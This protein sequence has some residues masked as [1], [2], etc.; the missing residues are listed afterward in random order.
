MSMSDPIADM[1]TRIRNSILREHK[2]VTL[3]SSLIKQSIAEVLKKEGFIENFHVHD[4]KVGSSL[5]IILKYDSKGDSIIR[6]INKISKPGL[7]VFKGCDD[8][9]PI[10]N[11]QGIYILTTSKGVLSDVECRTRNIGGEILCEVY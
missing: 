3:P 5:E 8:L 10:L 11:G 2:S 6:K 9:K 7:R 4:E 1:L